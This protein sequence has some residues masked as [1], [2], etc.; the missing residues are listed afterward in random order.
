[1]SGDWSTAG[2]L[3][4]LRETPAR[5][6]VGLDELT[7]DLGYFGSP[8]SREQAPG[9][10][11]RSDAGPGAAGPAERA[12][13]ERLCAGPAGLD[14]LVA[15]TGLPP[16]VVSGAMTLLLMRGWVQAHRPGLHRRR[17][18]CASCRMKRDLRTVAGAVR[19]ATLPHV[20][21]NVIIHLMNELPIVVDVDA[22][23]AG[24]DRSIRCT[25]VRTVDGKR[26][27]YVHDRNSTFV[28]PAGVDPPDRGSATGR[29]QVAKSTP[30]DAANPQWRAVRSQQPTSLR[31]P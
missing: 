9:S 16:G 14:L 29:V 20:I 7:E 4:L 23:P 18:P 10:N 26:P 31:R 12:V 15:E 8:P 22:L 24:A 3:A 17:S 13:A 28:F 25:N 19:A 6:F 21:T 11:S 1:M 5:P 2:S 27:S 30:T